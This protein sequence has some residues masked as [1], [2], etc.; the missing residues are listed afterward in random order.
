[1][2]DETAGEAV[3]T[4][5]KRTSSGVGVPLGMLIFVFG[6]AAG[7]LLA[8]SGLGLIEDTAGIILLAFL[9][10]LIFIGAFGLMVVIFRKPLL[11]RLFGFAETQLELFSEPLA[12]VTATRKRPRMRRAIWC[13]WRWP[14]TRGCRHGAGSSA[15]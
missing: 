8:F 10:I 3:A 13:I 12:R 6:T 2:V 15:R 7:F 11:R 4:T 1:M 14:A 9:C 5:S